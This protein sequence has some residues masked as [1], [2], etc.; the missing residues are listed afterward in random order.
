MKYY[1]NN[2]IS[3]QCL[4]ILSLGPFAKKVFDIFKHNSADWDSF[5]RELNVSVNFRKETFRTFESADSKL[6][7]VIQKWVES[8]CSPVNWL[9][10]RQVL[11]ALDMKSLLSLVPAEDQTQ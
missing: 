4:I 10:V 3:L 7:L 1:H 5:G 11:T 2:Y 8:E 6:D 9:T